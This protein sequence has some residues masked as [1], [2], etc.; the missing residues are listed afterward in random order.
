VGRQL[1]I[2]KL[3]PVLQRNRRNQLQCAAAHADCIRLRLR[4]QQLQRCSVH[5]L[6]HRQ[7]MRRHSCQL[8]LQRRLVPVM[9]GAQCMHH[10][11]MHQQRMRV[12]SQLRKLLHRRNLLCQRRIQPIKR[13]PGLQHR[14]KPKRMVQR[15]FRDKRDRLQF[16]HLQRA[17]DKPLCLQRR[18]LL[19]I[20]KHRD[21][22]L[23]HLQLLQSRGC[24]MRIQWNRHSLLSQRLLKVHLLW[25]QHHL[26]AIRRQILQRNR[27]GMRRCAGRM[28]GARH[29]ADFLRR[30]MQLLR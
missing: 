15:G 29:G 3:H 1:H 28:E 10:C 11:H 17:G 21:N 16:L 24:S 25:R 8:L 20:A 22:V 13:L 4:Q 2:R 30:P 26:P 12:L 6:R 14:H 7:R 18:R 27:I 5:H 19:H 23:G 9:L